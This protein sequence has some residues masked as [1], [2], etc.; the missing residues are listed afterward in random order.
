LDKDGDGAIDFGEF[1][2]GLKYLSWIA[3][4]PEAPRKALN[5]YIVSAAVVGIAVVGALAVFS[6]MKRAKK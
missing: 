1:V 4:G 2:A 3:G 5:I 6:F